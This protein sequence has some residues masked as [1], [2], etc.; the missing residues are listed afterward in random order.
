MEI[1]N[2]EQLPE[3]FVWHDS[4]GL[5]TKSLGTAG[6][7]KK[8]YVNIDY[9]PPKA[10]S[11]KYHSHSQQEEFF[12]IISGNGTL[13]IQNKELSVKQ[14]DFFAKPAGQNIA[15]TFFNSG[16]ESLVILDI[17]TN[18]K[19]DTCYY[20]DEDVYF[21]KSN[22]QRRVFRGSDLD[23]LWTSEPNTQNEQSCK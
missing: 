4:V 7:S 16:N 20:P 3:E 1:K 18:E 14:G 10:Y 23:K 9:V 2:I 11:T 6:G 5:I 13:R 21:Q 8:F 17:G 12:I 19:E 15:H 22:E